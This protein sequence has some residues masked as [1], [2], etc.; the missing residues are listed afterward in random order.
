MKQDEIWSISQV[1]KMS[2][3]TS[4]T[5]RHYH[6]IGLLK[7]IKV[8]H[9]G[10]RHY[11]REELLKLQRIL[12]FRQ[13][14]ISLGDI[15]AIVA[16]EKD[17]HEILEAHKQWLLAE[18]RRLKKLAQTVDKTMHMMQGEGT[19]TNDELF[20]GF[21]HEQYRD[22]AIEKYGKDEVQK[23]ED[24]WNK[25]SKQEQ[26]AHTQM[27]NDACKALT[28]L[29]EAGA[30]ADSEEA[31]EQVARHYKWVSKFWRPNA[32]AYK[33]LGQMYVDDP[34]FAKTYNNYGE[35]L[36][37]YLNEGIKEYSKNLD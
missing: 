27:H 19:M 14:D 7:P 36:A 35:G 37:E 28:E 20:D 31:Q 32:E 9:G 18:S 21:D 4:R 26:E 23:S 3:T 22:E 17:P 11:G 12:L 33:G 8:S 1:A 30:P 10:I 16:G 13:Q 29:R 24:N 2:G 15:K 34:R 6:D 5:L 25:M